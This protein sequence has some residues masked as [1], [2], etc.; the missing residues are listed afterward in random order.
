M[1]IYGISTDL[2]EFR[3]SVQIPIHITIDLNGPKRNGTK[4]PNRTDIELDNR[5]T[6]IDLNGPTYTTEG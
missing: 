1:P 3:Q 2:A 6:E 4:G 5:T